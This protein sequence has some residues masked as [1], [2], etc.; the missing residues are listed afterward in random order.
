MR[1][2]L[3]QIVVNGKSGLET[4]IRNFKK[5]IQK[6]GLIRRAKDIR[7]YLSKSKRLKL[8]KETSLNRRHRQR[9]TVRNA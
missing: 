7:Y 5:K 4:A 2:Q 3:T 1:L 6:L 8:K 9:K